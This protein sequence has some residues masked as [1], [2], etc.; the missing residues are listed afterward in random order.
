[1]EN[2]INGR[3][4]GVPV[5]RGGRSSPELPGL[6]RPSP[7][8]GFPGV[9]VIP[10]SG[11]SDDGPSLEVLPGAVPLQ[12][13]RTARLGKL[14]RRDSIIMRDELELGTA[15]SK[16]AGSD[17]KQRTKGKDERR[18]KKPKGKGFWKSLK[19][20]FSRS[21][22]RSSRVP[23]VRVRLPKSSS[24]GAPQEVDEEPSSRGG[25]IELGS[26]QEEPGAASGDGKHS[27]VEGEQKG[28]KV[29]TPEK[30]TLKREGPG[31]NALAPPLSESGFADSRRRRPS[32]ADAKRR[33]S[34]LKRASKVD[35]LHPL[36]VD[37]DLAGVKEVLAGKFKPFP[38]ENTGD[39][40]GLFDEEEFVPSPAEFRQLLL[41][42]TSLRAN[43]S[44]CH[45][46]ATGG[47]LHLVKLLVENGANVNQ[48]AKNQSIAL[49]SA[50]G[51][52]HR[53]VVKY[54]IE[55]GSNVNTANERGEIPL[56][57]ACSE[58][59]L[60]IVRWLVEAK[61]N[62]NAGAAAK[63]TTPLYE[64]ASAGH[65]PV[66]DFLLGNG[67]DRMARMSKGPD[68]RGKY[69]IEGAAKS[70]DEIGYEHELKSESVAG[71]DAGLSQTVRA[72]HN[73]EYSPY[74][75]IIMLLMTKVSGSKKPTD[76]DE[77][78]ADGGEG[79]T[80]ARSSRGKSTTEE[81]KEE[82]VDM[83]D[84]RDQLCALVK[85]YPTAAASA[86]DTGVS[87]FKA[88]G[89]AET[90]EY[91][92]RL[93]CPPTLRGE[94][95]PLYLMNEYQCKELFSHPLVNFVV[96]QKWDQFARR[97]YT[98]SFIGFLLY[99]VSLSVT[100]MNFDYFKA[101]D[102]YK[103]Y[104]VT[105]VF[106][107]FCEL[108]V[109]SW[110]ILQLWYTYEDLR[111]HSIAFI[112]TRWHVSILIEGILTVFLTLSKLL[113]VLDYDTEKLTLVTQALLTVAMSIRALLY[114]EVN[115]TL[116]GTIATMNSTL[117]GSA[118]EFLFMF[119]IIHTAFAVVCF[120]LL[121]HD[122]PQFDTF[123]NTFLELYVVLVGEL[124]LWGSIR[125]NTPYIGVA[126][127]IVYTFIATVILLNWLIALMNHGFENADRNR[128]VEAKFSRSRLILN[129][130]SR[131]I[132]EEMYEACNQEQIVARV[133]NRTSRPISRELAQFAQAC[134]INWV[135]IRTRLE[136]TQSLLRRAAKVGVANRRQRFRRTRTPS[137]KKSARGRKGNEGKA[138]SFQ[139]QKGSSRST[140]RGRAPV[141]PRVTS[142]FDISSLMASSGDAKKE[143]K[144]K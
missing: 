50:S 142:A 98:Y 49:H 17:A 95:Q 104:P 44:Y 124:E 15:T 60:D 93:V 10:A 103:Q 83:M 40:K 99:V 82:E 94:T 28:L 8:K 55:Q 105:G 72:V 102:D 89:T 144:R 140:A 131:W 11:P 100:I 37:D 73:T 63:K 22:S 134:E 70:W 52:G 114:A 97:M 77:K 107:F 125:E 41:H 36:I 113:L 79:E 108:V 33:K 126:T 29:P 6:V 91:D 7:Q 139:G 46:A 62:V 96:E 71:S 18:F 141:A 34:V 35:Y 27:G 118:T 129:L 122:I 121:R 80:C 56:H 87:R 68:D 84:R 42:G 135:H 59:N 58:G 47:K 13:A 1:M 38:Q 127:F 88:W 120:C 45:L 137:P 138:P 136:Y 112:M 26:L 123:I 85:N 53:E 2:D 86:L 92:T 90:V 61:A 14:V 16:K 39:A 54:L 128:Y 9:P 66:V 117:L 51:A 119:A 109:I 76:A 78:G 106:Y 101:F 67:A 32:A 4:G 111:N 81:S 116:G 133:E 21:F 69:P 74:K 3:R 75:E 132:S 110:G 23:V 5:R 57:Y 64:A 65:V 19:S 30:E 48:R 43:R 20:V 115:E 31:S 25:G 130:E 24:A 12:R 143:S